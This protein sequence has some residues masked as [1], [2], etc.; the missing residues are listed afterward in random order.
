MLFGFTVLENILLGNEKLLRDEALKILTGWEFLDF[1]ATL[2]SGFDTPLGEYGSLLSGGQRQRL[3]IA[4]ALLRKPALLIL[5]E[6]T[7]GLDSDTEGQVL[8][9]IR[10]YLPGATVVMISH[11]L[12][13]VKDADY[14]YVLNQG[15]VV[16][17][18][19]HSDLARGA[20][21]Y[22]QYAERQSLG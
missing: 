3:A 15:C 7:S 21:L 9:V 14:I 4:R 12:S 6:A 2:E 22:S 10:R 19:T 16:E 20:G 8:R 11:R 1:V 13:T 17:Q 18:G 5:D